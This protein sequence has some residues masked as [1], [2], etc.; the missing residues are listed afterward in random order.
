MKK[1]VIEKI[2]K[3]PKVYNSIMHNKQTNAMP[4]HKTKERV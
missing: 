1:P 4:V 3:M 2:Q